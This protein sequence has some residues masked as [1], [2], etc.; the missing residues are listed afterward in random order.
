MASR[1]AG[2]GQELETR[3]LFSIKRARPPGWRPLALLTGCPYMALCP[4]S[5]CPQLPSSGLPVRTEGVSPPA[6]QGQQSRRP[7]RYMFSL[8][9]CNVGRGLVRRKDAGPAPV[10]AGTLTGCVSIKKGFHFWKFQ[11]PCLI[12]G[13]DPLTGV[14]G[15]I[16]RAKPP[17]IPKAFP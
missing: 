11:F 4:F 2:C 8:L 15:S 14:T 13:Q 10:T 9:V 17:C 12:R 3:E 6:G 7:A 5:G 16:K 1:T